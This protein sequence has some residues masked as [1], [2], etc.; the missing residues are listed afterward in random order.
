MGPWQ[1]LCP[2]NPRS[3]IHLKEAIMA[4]S[5]RVGYAVVGLGSI[6]ENAI[7]PAFRTA[8]KSR[9][10]A[11]VSGDAAKAKRLAK[12]FHAPLSYTYEN[13]D[14]CL[15]NPDVEAVFVA[16]NNG[17]HVRF[18]LQAAAS[19]KHVICEKPMANT[20]EECERMVDACRKNKVKLMI[21][22]RKYFEP[23]SLEFK[24]LIA[25]G[26]LGRLKFLHT[27][28]SVNLPVSS[29]WHLSQSAAGGGALLDVGV[30]CVNTS[31]FVLG[32]DPVEA[33]GAYAWTVDPVRFAEVEETMSFQLK[34]PDS[35]YMQAT[36]SFGAIIASFLQV[37]G[38]KG[39]A[40]L[41]PSY[42]FDTQ[43]RMFGEI[44]GKWFEK[45]FPPIGEFDLELDHMAEC[46]RKKREPLADGAVGLRD[47]Q[48]M[49]AIYQS[50]R[51]KAPVAIP[52]AG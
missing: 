33:S 34:F 38:E 47:V 35:L 5:K 51:T 16:T 7:L 8:K 40:A 17:T 30:Y 43:R 3:P 1:P 50:E 22:Y 21:A 42:A 9:L 23:A 13:F 2:A 18:T 6:S 52:P 19:G 27:A 49:Q 25:S 14:E 26:K 41:D 45:K 37:H 4:T 15:R 44:G 48:I 20:V 29:Q 10:V 32:V 39:W 11:L 46:I 28:F 12:K 24:R 36:A 31:R